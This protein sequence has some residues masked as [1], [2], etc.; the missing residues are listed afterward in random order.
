MFIMLKCEVTL[1]LAAR[2]SLVA[3]LLLR[4]GSPRYSL[5]RLIRIRWPGERLFTAR[6]RDGNVHSV[7]LQE[8]FHLLFTGS[9]RESFEACR[10]S[11]FGVIGLRNETDSA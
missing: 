11:L 5:W 1:S 6:E 2:S 10:L 4:G 3:T 7:T 9:Y 8:D